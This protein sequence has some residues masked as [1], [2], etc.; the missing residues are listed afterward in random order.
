MTRVI[1]KW[2]YAWN[3]SKWLRLVVYSESGVIIWRKDCLW[4]R[5]QMG[6]TG[7]VRAL[8]MTCGIVGSQS[9]VRRWTLFT[10]FWCCFRSAV[11]CC[12]RLLVYMPWNFV[13]M[14]DVDGLRMYIGSLHNCWLQVAT[15]TIQPH[16]R[17]KL[18]FRSNRRR[19][20][21]IFCKVKPPTKKKLR[22]FSE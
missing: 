1:K 20:V 12:W 19:A 8:C 21:L 14:E 6:R 11:N 15:T 5:A 3:E 16:S 4:K 10:Q 22:V 2:R 18:N 7:N 13:G 17:G 9:L